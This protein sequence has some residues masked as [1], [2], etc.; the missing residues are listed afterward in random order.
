MVLEKSL[1]TP[2]LRSSLEIAFKA[3][4]NACA[5][6]GADLQDY[7]PVTRWRAATHAA[8]CLLGHLKKK[9]GAGSALVH[10]VVSNHQF[11]S[12]VHASGVSRDLSATV[13]VQGLSGRG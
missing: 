12:S 6:D 5:E 7:D 1:Q 9:V 4:A 3:R 13:K 8:V 2:C 10:K 11:M